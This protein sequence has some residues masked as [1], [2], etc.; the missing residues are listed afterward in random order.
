MSD[1]FWADDPY[2]LLSSSRF[3]EF[4]PTA[5]MT[6][7]E[8]INAMTRFA[9]YLGILLAVTYNNIIWLYIPV[10]AMLFFYFVHKYYPDN[11][12]GAGADDLKCQG[13]TCHDENGNL[14]QKP[15]RDNPFMNVL[16]TDYVDNPIRSPAADIDDPNIQK[17]IK[18]MFDYGLYKNVDDIWDRNNSQRQYYTNPGTTIPNDRDSFMNWCWNT[19]YVCKDGDQAACFRYDDLRGHGQL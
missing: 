7:V 11:Q 18:K 19:P 3:V 5:D 16:L 17:D 4:F 8:K 9:I 13:D 10:V 14:Y 2:I 12:H 6:R 1:P 15:T